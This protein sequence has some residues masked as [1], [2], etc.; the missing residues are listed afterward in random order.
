MRV[1]YFAAWGGYYEVNQTTVDSINN[2]GKF[3]G[4]YIVGENFSFE[5][6]YYLA[7][8]DNPTEFD[9][10]QDLPMTAE[11]VLGNVYFTVNGNEVIVTIWYDGTPY[12]LKYNF[13]SQ[14][15]MTIFDAEEIYFMKRSNK[16]Q[17]FINLTKDRLYLR[18]ML[19]AGSDKKPAFVPHVIWD[20]NTNTI[21][22][23]EKYNAYAYVKQNNQGALIAY[24]YVDE[25]IMDNI[26]STTLSYTSRQR[27]D[28][29]FGL[30]TRYTD[31]K[32]FIWSHTSEDTLHYRN[33][34][35]TWEWMIPGYNLIFLGLRATTYYEMPRI[36]ALDFTNLPSYYN[37]SKQE[38][39]AEYQ[40]VN[41]SFTQLKDNPR[42]KV[43][44]FALQEGKEFEL[45]WF[46]KIQTEFYN[47]PDNPDDPKNLKIIEI[48]YKTD[49]KLYTTVGKDMNLLITVEPKVDGIANED[50]KE[51]SPLLIP[52]IIFVLSLAIGFTKGQL[53]TRNGFN[54]K[55]VVGSLILSILV[56]FVVVNWTSIIK[57]LVIY[58]WLK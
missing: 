51:F 29:W 44:A 21:T 53:I 47:N 25:F 12:T 31:W 33:L 18:D 17:I 14:T 56:Y 1:M 42:Y 50:N 36:Q 5:I 43:W 58:P 9:S 54:F 23:M 52:L 38:I 30:V 41:A 3:L 19:S 46:G 40:K 27:S 7:I 6:R 11:N 57:S 15:D 39:E 37:V 32:T 4:T 22:K 49:D 24:Y 48:V 55:Y 26:I 2:D 34:T 45:G 16:P 8:V 28:E 20:L 13:S 35:S 10:V